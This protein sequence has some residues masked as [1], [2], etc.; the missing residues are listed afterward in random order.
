MQM[1][2]SHAM[3]VLIIGTCDA[4]SLFLILGTKAQSGKDA[5]A[6]MQRHAKPYLPIIKNQTTTAVV[7]KLCSSRTLRVEHTYDL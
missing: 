4:F 1:Q 2:R 3:S 5:E 7:H 6:K